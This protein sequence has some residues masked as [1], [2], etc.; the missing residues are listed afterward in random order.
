MKSFLL[1]L[2]LALSGTAMAESGAPSLQKEN[3]PEQI[4]TGEKEFVSTI[5]K[6]EKSTILEQ[7]GEPSKRTDVKNERTGEIIASIW[8][9]HFLNTSATD[10]NY[11]P[12]TE[13]DFVGDKVV[14]VVFMNHDGED[15]GKEPIE[16]PSDGEMETLP[17]LVPELNI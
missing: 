11:Y 4:P 9:Y 8:H 12:T 17:Q 6:Y 7:F 1:A 3:V 13:L 10:G 2:F 14:M 16:P 5:N 15:I